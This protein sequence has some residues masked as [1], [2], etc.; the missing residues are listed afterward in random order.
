[1]KPQ[2][3]PAQ[4]ELL[5]KLLNLPATMRLAP[6]SIPRQPKLSHYPLSLSQ[7]R[8]WMASQLEW[9]T[10]AYAIVRAFLLTGSM[11]IAILKKSLEVLMKRHSVLRTT[12]QADGDGPVQVVADEVPC[13]FSEIDLTA[14]GLADGRSALT[15]LI[16]RESQDPF[17]L[18]HGPLVRFLLVT[19]KEHEHALVAVMHHIVTD[20]WSIQ[21]LFRELSVI[22][23]NLRSGRPL[24]LAA[25]SIQYTDFAVW[26]RHLMEGSKFSSQ[27]A[28]WKQ[29]LADMPP[30]LNLS[31]KTKAAELG[32]S[33]VRLSLPITT[34]LW[35]GLR[36]LCQA[37]KAT[38]FEVLL[39][40]FEVLIAYYTGA[41]DIAI[42]TVISNRD[43]QELEPLVGCLI[44]T[45]ILRL[46]LAADAPFTL[47]LNEVKES[48]L[49]AQNN[50]DVPFEHLLEVLQPGRTDVHAPLAQILFSLQNAAD[51]CLSLPDI[52]VESIAPEHSTSTFDLSLAP[53]QT[54]NGL[55]IVLQYNTALFE[56]QAVRRLMVHYSKVLEAFVANP[57]QRISEVS[58]L[59][60]DEKEQ[61]RV[62]QEICTDKMLVPDL[63]EARAAQIPDAVAIVFGSEQLSYRE[64]N[65]RAHQLAGHLKRLGTGAEVRVAICM[66]RGLEMIVAMLGV[67]KSGAAYVPLDP[68]YPTERLSYMLQDSESK[69][70]L[71]QQALVPQ[72]PSFSGKV[73]QLDIEWGQ[74]ASNDP[75]NLTRTIHPENV[76]YIIYT[77]GSTG[78][79]K[80]VAIR[81]SSVATLVHWARDVFSADE[82]S[83]VLAST[84]LCFDL[85]IFEILVTLS[86]GGSVLVVE[87]ALDVATIATSLCVTLINTVPSIMR[88]LLRIDAIPT[89]VQTINIAGEALPAE[90]VRAIYAG[91]RALRVFNLY[92]PSEDTTYSTYALL[93]Q[94]Y[95]N[96]FVPIGRPIT[97]TQVYVLNRWLQPVP[98]GVTGELYLGGEGLARGYINRTDLTAQR[99]VPNPF[100]TTPGERLYRTGD[101][102]RFMPDGCLDFCGRVDHQVKLRGYRI[103]LGE[104]EAALAEHGSVAQ[105]V[106]V[107]REDEFG[108]KRLVAYVTS[109]NKG[110]ITCNDLSEHLR[111]HLPQY[112]VPDLIVQLSSLPL[113]A[114][115]KI[116]RSRLPEATYGISLQMDCVAPGTLEEETLCK[117]WA[118]V[119]QKNPIGVNQD[120]FT[121]GGH[122]LLALQ[123]SAQVRV[124]FGVELPLRAFF[125]ART[126]TAMAAYIARQRGQEQRLETLMKILQF[127]LYQSQDTA[128]SSE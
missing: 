22:Y 119:L 31:T 102:V 124:I 8:F 7:A 46:R 23:S 94:D 21:I 56:E 1:M 83:G 110:Q 14:L 29:Q 35:Q 96:W 68:T 55:N 5:K 112:M 118:E 47:V 28:Y 121:L 17:D 120:F 93:P 91:N 2:L 32:F 106:V 3:S 81:H 49:Q 52:R 111:R 33:G 123:I 27:V 11:D 57:E 36:N 65:D 45:V 127:E 19:L 101:L 114:N 78:K 113:T 61:L 105:A 82:L 59:A 48:M 63:F 38:L 34:E 64:L 26:Q 89:S 4:Q 98:V 41:D 115:G 6:S 100:S 79:P 25:P 58:L 103:E 16:R 67:L 9:E 84:S 122:S 85:S 86:C 88:E 62:W 80:G 128:G 97:N 92:G 20:D 109:A 75:Q 30:P 72:L 53:E 10:P 77:S 13:P 99:F 90:L 117:L 44:N 54:S 87:N 107:V 108:G 125:E 18:C 24:P 12:F 126:I 95:D 116:D 104:I 76:A 60:E 51:V 40:G 42:A 70:L 71:T 50:K 15:E 66:E 73:I 37:S 39:T 43:R 69:I 74:I